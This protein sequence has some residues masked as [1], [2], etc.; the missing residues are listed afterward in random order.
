MLPEATTSREPY[1]F[2]A[3][4]AS[5]ARR[6]MTDCDRSSV[7]DACWSL[8]TRVAGRLKVAFFAGVGI[9]KM[10]ADGYGSCKCWG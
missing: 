4:Y 7:F 1:F 10:L 6:T 9:G 5:S 2:G 3:R 8:A